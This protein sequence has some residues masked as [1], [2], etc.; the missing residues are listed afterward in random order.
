MSFKALFSFGYISFMT[1]DNR[2]TQ[3]RMQFVQNVQSLASNAMFSIHTVCH[4]STNTGT[5]ITAH[6]EESVLDLVKW[7]AMVCPR[8]LV[9]RQQ[10]DFP[11]LYS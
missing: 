5:L 10:P 8:G 3:G 4:V 7:A 1:T 2:T 9:L 11:T 6:N